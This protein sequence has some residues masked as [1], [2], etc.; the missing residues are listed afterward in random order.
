MNNNQVVWSPFFLAN[1]RKDESLVKTFDAKKY[2]EEK[3][4]YHPFSLGKKM[5]TEETPKGTRPKPT[6]RKEFVIKPLASYSERPLR[7]S[8]IERDKLH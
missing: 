6:A 8:K 2:Q 3:E 5:K 1:R 4:Y 7:K